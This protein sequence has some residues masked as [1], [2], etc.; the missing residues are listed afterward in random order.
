[1][2]SEQIQDI[3]AAETFLAG[4]ENEQDIQKH[5]FMMV[6]DHCLEYE[7]QAENGSWRVRKARLKHAGGFECLTGVDQHVASLIGGFDGKTMLGEQVAAFGARLNK[8]S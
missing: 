6:P 1:S 4:L 5:S 7:L 2:C 8:E 3:F